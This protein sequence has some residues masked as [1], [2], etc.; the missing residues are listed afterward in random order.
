MQKGASVTHAESIEQA[1]A[2]LRSAAARPA[3][4]RC[5]ARH[6]RTWC[7]GS[8]PSALWCGSS[9]AAPATT[10]RGGR[11][12]H[13]GAKEYIPL[14]PDPELIAAVLAAVTDDAREAHLSRRD[15][16]AR[17]ETRANR[18]RLR[19]LRADHGE[20]GTGKEVLARYVHSRRT[21]A[22]A[23]FNLG[24][25]CCDPREPARIGIVRPREGL[26]HRRRR[27]PHRQIGGG[28]RGTLLLDEISEWTRACRQ[29][30]CA[31]CRS[32]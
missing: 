6:P 16:G 9:P 21:G 18:S 10:R 7:C 23:A 30:C 15:D 17:G 27:A 11:G 24:Q 5:R 3:D 31:P 4:G 13:A 20:S 8:K 22:R 25:L 12:I 26:V 19:R 14:P 29:S 2:V 32:A 1:L 28:D